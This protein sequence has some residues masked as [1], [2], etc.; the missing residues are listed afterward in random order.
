MKTADALA[1]SI[2]R[3]L[4]GAQ[5][6]RAE[7]LNSVQ[8]FDLYQAGQEVGDAVARRAHPLKEL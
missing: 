4:T 5:N 7:R 1:S 3:H 6:V 2:Q 8:P